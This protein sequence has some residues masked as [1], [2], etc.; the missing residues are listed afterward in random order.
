ML[1]NICKNF[2]LY[3]QFLVFFCCFGLRLRKKKS[4]PDPDKRTHDP[5]HCL[6]KIHAQFGL[7]CCILYW[8]N[9]HWKVRYKKHA[10]SFDNSS[11]AAGDDRKCS[12][13]PAT[14]GGGEGWTDIPFFCPCIL[15]GIFS[16]RWVINTLRAMYFLCFFQNL[17]YFI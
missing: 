13:Q 3:L 11:L 16:Y 6:N 12:G 7:L 4:D 1:N 14:P 8:K 10:Y 9:L 15:K 5:K 2:N 17:D